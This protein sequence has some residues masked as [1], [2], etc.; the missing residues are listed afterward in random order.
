MNL[1]SLIDTVSPALNTG[2][3]T[4]VG[5][6]MVQVFE[7]RLWGYGGEFCISVPCNLDLAVAFNPE[8]V[9]SFFAVDR[10][11]AT[12][13]TEGRKLVIRSGKSSVAVPTIPRTDV[14]VLTVFGDPV[15]A[16]L[17]PKNLKFAAGLVDPDAHRVFA[18]GVQFREGALWAGKGVDLFC[19]ASGLP[20][21]LPPFTLCR[22]S[23][24][25]LATQK[26]PLRA[27]I[28]DHGAGYAVE[29]LFESG[30]HIAC[31]TIE[32]VDTSLS[33]VFEFPVLG[34][35]ALDEKIVDEILRTPATRWNVR[36]DAI[37]YRTDS[38]DARIDASEGKIE[39]TTGLDEA[40][41]PRGFYVSDA[42]LKRGLT[43]NRTEISVTERS[44]QFD[45]D[46]CSYVVAQM[47]LPLTE[48]ADIPF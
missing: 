36:S 5:A 12:F 43:I 41:F 28:V 18:R 27:V 14:M 37:H 38:D 44:L 19:G 8:P 11:G 21:G 40:A 32:T 30:V 7:E 24:K 1:K 25:V 26:S 33:A 34:E 17:V 20:A 4:Q 10:A 2:S 23:V 39:T 29:F 42:L 48:N 22:D 31:R 16:T 3:A 46:Q 35:V 13:T 15:P 6:S 45:G 47:T 9:R